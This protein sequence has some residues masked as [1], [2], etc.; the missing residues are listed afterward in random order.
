MNNRKGFSLVELLATI[1]IIGILAS[2]TIFAVTRVIDKSKNEKNIT[3]VKSAT[4]AAKSY[5]QANK[6]LAPK[7]IGETIKIS[8]Q[9][10]KD[11]KYLTEDIIRDDGENCMENS[12]I[13]VIKTGKNTYDYKPHIYCGS[14]VPPAEDALDP[15]ALKNGI[16]FSD[17]ND[18]NV[19][20]F[21][22]TILGSASNKNTTITSYTY[23]ISTKRDTQSDYQEVYNSGVLN[24]EKRTEINVN[25]KIKK[26]VD[27][28][29][30]TS[31]RLTVLARNSEGGS[32]DEHAETGTGS[33]ADY[34]DTIPPY[35]EE[36]SANLL[37]YTQAKVGEWF[38]RADY[39]S[40]GRG[41]SIQVKCSD[42]DGSGCL[43]EIFTQTWPNN[44]SVNNTQP[45]LYGAKYAWIYIKDNAGN[46]GTVKDSLP[47]DWNDAG[48]AN[49]RRDETGDYRCLVRVNVDIL[50]PE[51]NVTVKAKAGDSEPVEASATVGGLDEQGN[52]RNN[53]GTIDFDD[54]ENIA[55]GADKNKWFNSA[56]S[57]EG[58]V[59][60]VTAKDNI[61]L[62]SWTW[63]T[64]AAGLKVKSSYSNDDKKVSTSNDD[65]E[66]GEFNTPTNQFVDNNT[67]SI[68]IGLPTDGVRYGKLTVYDRAGNATVVYINAFVDKTPP[69]VKRLT[70]NTST[71][72]SND[73]RAQNESEYQPGTWTNKFVRAYIAKNFK[74]DNVSLF[75]KG[76][77]NVYDLN[78]KLLVTEETDTNKDEYFG[79]KDQTAFVFT[80]DYQGQD[81]IEFALCDNANNCSEYIKHKPEV[82]LDTVPPKCEVE[83][84]MKHD[85]KVGGD[86][87][88][89]ES[90]W[91][92]IGEN[93]V[94]TATCH[95]DKREGILSI[96]ECITE[97]FSHE[98]KTDKN[99]SNGG[100]KDEGDGGIV[101]DKAGNTKECSATK[102]IKIDHKAPDCT[103][104]VTYAGGDKKTS[105]DK[106][107]GWL[108]EGETATVIATC[109]DQAQNSVLSECHKDFK[110]LKHLYNSEI[111]TTTAGAGVRG[112]NDGGT[113]KDNADNVTECPADR[114]V[115][116]DYTK[117]K[118]D[119]S[120]ASYNSKGQPTSPT[121]GWLKKG[122]YVV[123]TAKCTDKDGGSGCKADKEDEPYSTTT[124]MNISNAGPNG[125]GVPFSFKDK[126]GNV[127]ETCKTDQ[128][129]KI[130]AVLPTCSYTNCPVTNWTNADL[131][132]EYGGRDNESGIADGYYKI[133]EIALNSTRKTTSV[134]AFDIMDKAGNTN[135]CAE[136][137][138]V[139]NID[140]NDPVPLCDM[141]GTTMRDLGSHDK[142]NN[143]EYS[144]VSARYYKSI[145][146]NYSNPNDLKWTNGWSTSAKANTACG[147]KTYYN[148]MLV[149]DKAGNRSVKKCGSNTTKS[150]CGE[151]NPK[152]C[153]WKTACRAGMTAIYNSSNKHD[154]TFVGTIYHSLNG[155]NDR[156]YVIK[157]DTSYYYGD[158]YG[159]VETPYQ[160]WNGSCHWVHIYRNCIGGYNTIC[161]Y[162]TCPG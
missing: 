62:A 22:F 143:V 151:S 92:G 40:S 54:Y 135:S 94:V 103:T 26:Y 78:H 153:T 139:T 8:F 129:V 133:N 74:D 80:S 111:S 77:Y 58:P 27:L 87:E 106:E 156:V 3:E 142:V 34:R 5:M 46:D 123:V 47:N 18:V 29:G 49:H 20:S 60:H 6:E 44:Q 120:K 68:D 25:E 24:G 147:G 61:E 2:V 86:G 50:E 117:P 21:S 126:A 31:V 88:F 108:M 115:R 4:L 63:E 23:I 161:P 42:G 43:R 97:P 112:N 59:I 81:T 76:K 28:T 162:S 79:D 41:K 17:S 99:I 45:Y 149:V 100:A 93:I 140:K 75:H 119:V 56:N 137:T 101:E 146:T 35:C 38:N 73:V 70:V 9:E 57:P 141:N 91:A 152:G 84:T 48:D 130:D 11:T 16:I 134:P 104:K 159:Y 96:S 1:V 105:N 13:E 125:A 144:G 65:S 36:N 52:R 131:K 138:C 32:L 14:E 102:T 155:R 55:K 39:E 136:K 110:T 64:N 15:P 69:N 160:C 67:Y 37:Q 71:L 33:Y 127:S 113:V 107:S 98:Y 83:R 128:V 124:S 118:C 154:G 66:I 158:L 121:N 132:I 157:E 109:E 116:I 30:T 90:D 145:T 51:V 12:Y 89:S 150:C 148:Y 114:T 95:D 82:W 85:P 7:G 122:D 10:L 53:S 19:A 72:Q